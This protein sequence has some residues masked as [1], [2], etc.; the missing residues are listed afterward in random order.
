E[1]LHR[2]SVSSNM[3]VDCVI[4]M[5]PVISFVVKS[6]VDLLFLCYLSIKP[7]DGLTSPLYYSLFDSMPEQAGERQRW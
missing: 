4:A 5:R 3:A 2:L 1:I 7:L 6:S